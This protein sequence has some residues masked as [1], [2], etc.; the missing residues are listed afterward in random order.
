M[1]ISP[2]HGHYQN[3]KADSSSSLLFFL[4]LL[5]CGSHSTNATVI[6]PTDSISHNE[7]T[8]RLQHIEDAPLDALL[9][10]LDH[11][12]S[13]GYVDL[14]IQNIPDASKRYPDAQKKLNLYLA[15]YY[16]SQNQINSALQYTQEND[17]YDHYLSPLVQALYQ[18]KQKNHSQ[19]EKTITAAINQYKDCAYYQNTLGRI[20]FDQMNYEKAKQHF[21]KA[22][23]I[24]SEFIP[25]YLNLSVLYS[26]LRQYDQAKEHLEMA[27]KKDKRLHVAYRGLALL[28]EQGN[29]IQKAADTLAL[30]FKE[31]AQPTF[32]SDLFSLASRHHRFELVTNSANL[33]MQT[34]EL[35]VLRQLCH[36][37]LWRQEFKPLFQLVQKQEKKFEALSEYQLLGQLAMK[38]YKAAQTTYERLPKTSEIRE[39]PSVRLLYVLSLI[40][41]EQIKTAESVLATMKVPSL[42]QLVSHVMG[43]V[44]VVQKRL[45]E[46]VSMFASSQNLIPSYRALPADGLASLKRIKTTPQAMADFQLSILFYLKNLTPLALHQL[47]KIKDRHELYR[48]WYAVFLKAL[49]NSVKAINEL[50]E[51][52]KHAPD[53]Y[54]SHYYLA[55]LLMQTGQTP[56]AITAY[57]RVIAQEIDAGTLL[58]LGLAYEKI[59]NHDQA[60]A[61]YQ[62][63][64]TTFPDLF[65]GY[66]QLAWFYVKQGKKLEAAL[67]LAEKANQLINDNASVLDTLGWIHFQK[68]SYDKALD[69]LKKSQSV[70]PDNPENQYHLAATLFKLNH[71]ELARQHLLKSIDSGASFDG[72]EDAKKLLKQPKSP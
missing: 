20:Y 2:S 71:P 59:K 27:L 25:A 17:L 12:I 63:V 3:K 19:A 9:A 58:K 23:Q 43:G 45:P 35:D 70:L 66:N 53:H 52:I 22:N 31:T 30:G 47:E 13:K 62:N 44:L 51:N 38:Q 7:A 11:A 42:Q 1:T 61:S 68:K 14:I 41:S 26:S 50:Q 8:S 57:N 10:I 5:I 21:L 49:G 29:Q 18:L 37:Y 4:I 34:Q 6:S 54:S 32:L 39:L 16:L 65:M 67:Q 69:Y 55:D 56:K 33:F 72:I 28:H 60:E 40:A 64:I 15:F 36:A 48:F 46:A 24:E